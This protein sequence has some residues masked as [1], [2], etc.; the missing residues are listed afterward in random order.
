MGQ[1]NYHPHV[2]GTTWCAEVH[3]NV[4]AFFHYGCQP[5]DTT[6]L[7]LSMLVW[8][9]FHQ[10]RVRTYRLNRVSIVLADFYDRS[11]SPYTGFP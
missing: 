2:V 6:Y 4:F 5:L 7:L 9:P 3:P 10:H 11:L 1:S 8:L